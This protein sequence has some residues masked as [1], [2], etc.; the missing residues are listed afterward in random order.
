MKQERDR[1]KGKERK[2]QEG[3]ERNYLRQRKL[4]RGDRRR[5]KEEEK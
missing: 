3:K 5:G 4:K 1:E 2:S